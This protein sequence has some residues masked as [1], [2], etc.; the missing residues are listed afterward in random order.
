MV[1]HGDWTTMTEEEIDN[2]LKPALSENAKTA[3]TNQ[4][5]DWQK[6]NYIYKCTGHGT[7]L[8]FHGTE[9]ITHAGKEVYTLTY[10]STQL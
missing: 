4:S 8:D 10:R 2:I 5:V 7:E 1:Y 6:D 3:R 9:T